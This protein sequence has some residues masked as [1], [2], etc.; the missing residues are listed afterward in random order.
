M[1]VLG[2][3]KPVMSK[4]RVAAGDPSVSL[5][6]SDSVVKESD[7][8]DTASASP[9]A[10]YT[11]SPLVHAGNSSLHAWRGFSRIDIERLWVASQAITI[12]TLSKYRVDIACLSEVHLPY[13][14]SRVIIDPE[15]ELANHCGASDNS[16]RNGVAIVMS[17]KAH[18]ALIE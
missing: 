5:S 18:S 6:P 4:I 3:N 7:I 12:H 11:P 9:D 1:S 15:S 8:L 17:D 16:E 2:R 13:F 14:G 10:H